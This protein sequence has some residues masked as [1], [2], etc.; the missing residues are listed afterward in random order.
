MTIGV[1]IAIGI[2]VGLLIRETAVNRFQKPTSTPKFFRV[3]FWNF[4]ATAAGTAKPVRVARPEA[5]GLG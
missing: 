5:V 1:G 3:S 2:G 4:Q